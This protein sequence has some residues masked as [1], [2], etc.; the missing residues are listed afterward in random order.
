M[1]TTH[2][3]L[4]SEAGYSIIELLVS[5][6]IMITVTGA[7][8]GLVNPSQ[9][10]SQTV[11][12]VSDLQQRARVSSDVLF[13]E[14]LM[15]GAGTYQGPVR[16]PLLSF[17]APVIPRRMGM[18]APDPYNVFKTDAI[19]VHYIP[20]TYSQTT[21]TNSM[22]PNSNELKVA[23]QPNCPSG[24]QLCGFEE[25]ME[26]II[27]DTSGH[28]DTFVITQ[29]Q[30]SAGHLQHQGVDLSYGYDVGASVTVVRGYG[31][32]LDR[33]TN[34]LMQ[35]TAGKAVPIV[36]NVVDLRFDYFG[37]PAPPTTPKPD[38]GNANCLYD[39]TGTLLPMPTLTPDEG[40]LATLTEAMLEDGPWC[41]ANGNRFDA[42]LY[43]LRKVRVTLRLQVAA[44]ALRGANTLLFRNPGVARDSARQVPDYRVSFDVTP[45]NLNLT[46]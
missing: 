21:I 19:T 18:I 3:R 15:A 33:N 13:K 14:L 22:P 4:R 41:G 17:F 8:F 36:D 29:V 7:I 27:F 43:R 25:G 31:F 26:V 9:G 20:N 16:S 40:P 11:P 12:E 46:R 24:H 35:E 32:Y 10:T 38:A 37:D 23:D 1:S 45:R 42:D 34:Q 39:A 5:S 28:F 6:A 44:A 2:A 30:D